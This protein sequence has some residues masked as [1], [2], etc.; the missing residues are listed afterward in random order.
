MKMDHIDPKVKGPMEKLHR[1][2]EELFVYECM[3]SGLPRH[4]PVHEGYLG[5][6][7]EHPYYYLFFDREASSVVGPWLVKQTGWH[8][9][10]IYRM[11]YEQW[12]QISR[13][14]IA[15][16]P[17]LI[18]SWGPDTDDSHGSDGILLRLDPGLVFGSGLHPSTRGCLLTIGRIFKAVSFK[19]VVDL[20]TGSGILA[21]ACALM[22]ARRVVALDCNPMAGRVAENNAHRNGLKDS[23]HL[24]IAEDLAA[25]REPSE[26]LLMNIE[27][28]CLKRVLCGKEWLNHP[29][30]VLSGFLSTQR[31]ELEGLIPP[32]WRE[33]LCQTIEGWQTVALCRGD[34]EASRAMTLLPG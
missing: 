33:V 20:G 15:V 17:F 19:T 4:E 5:L 12:Q 3:G 22:G 30:V 9:R 10:S 32:G 27:F 16:P 6:W 23:V 28:P 18:R 24:L 11:N 25:L 34:E 14:D 29:W 7:P 1:K 2:S 8:F 31:D 21:L 13:E 26:L